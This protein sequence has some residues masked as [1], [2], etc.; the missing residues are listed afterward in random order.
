MCVI[1]RGGAGV[2]VTDSLS[3]SDLLIFVII[4]FTLAILVTINSVVVFSKCY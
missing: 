2:D 4:M 3:K 1:M